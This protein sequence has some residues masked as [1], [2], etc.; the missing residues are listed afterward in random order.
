M[1]AYT[2]WEAAKEFDVMPWEVETFEGIGD[3]DGIREYWHPKGQVGGKCL[4]KRDVTVTKCNK[5]NG[6][7]KTAFLT[8][9]RICNKCNGKVYIHS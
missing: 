3:F 5:C 7:G 9:H 8:G 4:Y 6:T 2:R 1:K